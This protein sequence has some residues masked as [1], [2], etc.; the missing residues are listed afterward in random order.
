MLNKKISTL[1]KGLLILHSLVALGYGISILANPDDIAAFMGLQIIST[2]GLAELYVMYLGLSGAMSLFMLFGA[3]REK[4]LGTALF[5][6]V[7]SM[8]GITSARLI[9]ALFLETGYYTNHSLYYDIPVTFLA[10][11][12]YWK[13]K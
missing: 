12:A 6:L 11:F 4:W 1:A 8:S 3:F 10:W 13:L 9:S 2:D 7:L 5:F